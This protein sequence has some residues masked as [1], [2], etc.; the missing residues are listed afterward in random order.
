MCAFVDKRV[1]E[2]QRTVAVSASD[3]FVWGRGC[4]TRTSVYFDYP[5]IKKVSSTGRT[6]E[7]DAPLVCR[8]GTT[9]VARGGKVT[10]RSHVATVGEITLE[11]GMMEADGRQFK[12][13]ETF[14][15]QRVIPVIAGYCKEVD[16]LL[17]TPR[18]G[19]VT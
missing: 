2:G 18:L 9:A 3:V 19:D 15:S 7:L 5:N 10:C 14:Q 13:H 8:S 17:T 1:L 6:R 4:A 11:E 12:I 16:R